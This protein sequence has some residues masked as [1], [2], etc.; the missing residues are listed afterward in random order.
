[1][2]QTTLYV[3]MVFLKIN[4]LVEIGGKR[5]GGSFKPGG[6]GIHKQMN[7]GFSSFS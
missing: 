6:G 3:E 1:M 4:W 5:K 2:V 7:L